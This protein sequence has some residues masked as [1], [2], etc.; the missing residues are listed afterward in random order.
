MRR[1]RGSSFSIHFGNFH[2][3]LQ[4]LT[5][6]GIVFSVAFCL[7]SSLY[8]DSFHVARYYLYETGD[9]ILEACGFRSAYDNLSLGA[10][11]GRPVDRIFERRGYAYGYA[12]KLEQPLWVTYKLTIGELSGMKQLRTD[13]FRE[14]PRILTRSASPDDY[15]DS[16]FDRGHLAPAADMSWDREIMS[17]SFFMSNMSPQRPEFNRGVWLDLENLVR[18]F[19]RKEKE[20]FIVTGPVFEPGKK[21]QT[22]GA[23][24]VVVPDAFYK[25]VLDLTPPRKMIGFI[26]P[27]RR[28]S[29]KLAKYACTVKAVEDATGLVFFPKLDP[30]EAGRL[31]SSVTL[32]DWGL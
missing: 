9:R 3:S 20:V 1:R 13:D 25:V 6:I 32:A 4:S 14:D 17:E 15:K 18:S 11:E 31:K 28:G 10:P 26:V 30:A 24:R 16:G 5:W 12:E 21:W 2:F 29:K 22:I 23:N 7:W 8:F 27:N 19:A